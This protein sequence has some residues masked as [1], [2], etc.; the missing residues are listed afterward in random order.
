MGNI[1]TGYQLISRVNKT[2]VTGKCAFC[3][4]LYLRTVF[5]IYYVWFLY[6]YMCSHNYKG[7][8]LEYT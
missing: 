8:S 6:A 3:V 4:C 7:N 2:S 5:H 1:H